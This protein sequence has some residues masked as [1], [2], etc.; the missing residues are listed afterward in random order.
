MALNLS[1]ISIIEKNKLTSDG[2]WLVLLEIQIAKDLIIR[3]V[4]N[5]E[6]IVWNGYTWVAFPFELD[7]IKETSQGEL[8]QIPV[9]VSN[10]SRSVQQ[11]IEQANGGVGA[12][13]I[14]RVVH[15]QHLDILAADIEETFTV[16]HVSSDSMWVTF[17]LGG[18]MPTMLRFPFRRVLKDFCPFIYKGIECGAQSHQENCNKTLGDCRERGNATRFGGEPSIPQGGIYASNR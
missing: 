1:N 2:A 4:R 14:L 18:D 9:R 17:D 15:S 13:V 3:I 7:E 8:P 12:T 5:T 16:Q 11:Y 10:V 6:D